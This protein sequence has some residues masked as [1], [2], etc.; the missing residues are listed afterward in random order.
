V[1]LVVLMLFAAI[2]APIAVPLRMVVERVRRDTRRTEQVV[3]Q[4]ASSGQG[5]ARP[6][7]PPLPST[8]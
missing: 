7:E 8:V 1:V 4:V 3:P 5:L 6:H 2:V